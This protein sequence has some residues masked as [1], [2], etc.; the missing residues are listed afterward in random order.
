MDGWQTLLYGDAPKQFVLP[1]DVPK[2]YAKYA[3]DV[4]SIIT[5]LTWKAKQ[6][7]PQASGD[8]SAFRY[9]MMLGIQAMT[10]FATKDCIPGV[11]YAY[12]FDRMDAVAMNVADVQSA[13]DFFVQD[14]SMSLQQMK[15]DCKMLRE[16]LVASRDELR[17]TRD[18]LGFKRAELA[19][20]K[21]ELA[22][23]KDEACMLREYNARLVIHKV[24]PYI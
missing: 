7:F 16:D 23:C 8:H 1:D 9:F 10:H 3:K 15:A 21:E 4:D 18:E 22:V 19:M 12:V 2:R 13:A 11:M 5:K 24:G 6:V 17:I 20:A 14:L